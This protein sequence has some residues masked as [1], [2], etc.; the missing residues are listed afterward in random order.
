MYSQAPGS[1]LKSSKK[2][3]STNLFDKENSDL[4]IEI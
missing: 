1:Q 2:E 4:L 3:I